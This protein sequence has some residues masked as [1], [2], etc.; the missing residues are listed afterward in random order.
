MDV[1]K[2]EI[3]TALQH[4]AASADHLQQL[5]DCLFDDGKEVDLEDCAS[6]ALCYARLAARCIARVT[7]NLILGEQFDYEQ[8]S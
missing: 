8:T 7:D 6:R 3:I 1:T 4:L 2:E 5:Y